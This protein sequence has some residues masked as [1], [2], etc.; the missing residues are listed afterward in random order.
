[1]VAVGLVFGLS[2]KQ[3]TK[4]SSLSPNEG[5]WRSGRYGLVVALAVGLVF[6]LVLGLVG[7]LSSHGRAALRTDLWAIWRATCLCSTLHLALLALAIE[8]PAL[9]PRALLRRGS[10]AA[11]VTQGGREL[12]LRASATPRLLRLCRITPICSTHESLTR[13]SRFV[14]I[15]VAGRHRDS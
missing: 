15:M 12:Y 3:L 11:T 6:G 10:Q 9:E 1:M 4:R 5:I 2:G 13:I 14:L 8:M 7:G